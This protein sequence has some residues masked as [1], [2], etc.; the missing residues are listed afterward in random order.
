M[1]LRD[2]QVKAFAEAR[3]EA[4]IQ[5]M[6]RHLRDDLGYEREKRKIADEDIEDL[7]RKGIDKAA[8]YQV[9]CEDDVEMYLDCMVLL[10]PD[11]DRDRSLGWAGEI[12]RDETLDGEAKMAQIEQ[13]ML[14]GTEQPV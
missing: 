11:F 9:V 5:R 8:G 6:V 3:K 13:Q 4:Y 1:I 2:E 7:V 10:G 14:F 12:L